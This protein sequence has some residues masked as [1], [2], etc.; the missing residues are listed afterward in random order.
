MLAIWKNQE[1]GLARVD[2]A[3]RG[4]WTDVR[5]A[6][7]DDLNLLERDF[8]ILPEHL[9]DIMDLDEQSRIEKEDEYSLLIV[10]LPVFDARYEVSYYT[11]PVGFILFPDRVVTICS[12]DSEV[13]EELLGGGRRALDL[14]NKSAF[15]L[16]LFGRAAIVYLRYLKDINRRTAVI[17]QELQRSVKNHELTQLLAFEKS[18]VFFTTSLKSNEIVL[19]K[20]QATKTIRF[21]EDETE[22]LED[23][24]TDNKQAIEMANIYSDILSG[25][26]DA[27]ASVISNN[28]NIQMKRLTVIS[29]VLMI[30]TLIVSMF[31]MNVKVPL[32]ELPNAFAII[33]GICVAAGSVGALLLSGRPSRRKPRMAKTAAGAIVAPPPYRR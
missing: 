33:A 4:T 8:G 12:G 30:P 15:V 6:T 25:M 24:L 1:T 20:L 27:F 11:A 9:Q 21:K 14:K 32:G 22:L 17:E 5:N 23:V 7:R 10:R 19:E 31:G 3:E 2:S 18:L 29:I 28:L 16:K 26:M 13:L